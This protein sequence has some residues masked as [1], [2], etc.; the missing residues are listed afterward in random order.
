M[1]NL[2]D[3]TKFSLLKVLGLNHPIFSLVDTKFFHLLKAFAFITLIASE[4]L[5]PPP[6]QSPSP[7]FLRQGYSMKP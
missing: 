3:R 6:P 5:A 2:R 1:L 4:A 7:L